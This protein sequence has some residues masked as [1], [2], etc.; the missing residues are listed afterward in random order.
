MVLSVVL[1]GIACLSVKRYLINS[2][3]YFLLTMIWWSK[4]FKKEDKGKRGQESSDVLIENFFFFFYPRKL[5]RIFEREQFELSMSW[6]WLQA[7]SSVSETLD[8]N[9]F[10]SKFVSQRVYCTSGDKFWKNCIQEL[11]SRFDSEW[12]LRSEWHPLSTCMSLFRL[13]YLLFV[14]QSSSTSKSLDS[15]IAVDTFDEVLRHS[16]SD[17]MWWSLTWVFLRLEYK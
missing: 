16:F 1:R 7:D 11:A 17:S 12:D 9:L 15:I 14:R 5:W 8:G 4:S 10:P 2:V 6:S 3:V 13:P